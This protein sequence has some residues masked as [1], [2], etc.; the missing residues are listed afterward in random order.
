MSLGIIGKVGFDRFMVLKYCY[1]GPVATA[2]RDTRKTVHIPG[3]PVTKLHD[4]V[5]SGGSRREPQHSP[6]FS[7]VA[8]PGLQGCAVGAPGLEC[9]GPRMS[10]RLRNAPSL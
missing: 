1:G 10:L 9:S 5:G 2:A 4:T 3:S 8:L 6:F 7:A